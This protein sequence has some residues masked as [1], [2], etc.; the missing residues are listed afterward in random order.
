MSKLFSALITVNIIFGQSTTQVLPR[1]SGHEHPSLTEKVELLLRMKLFYPPLGFGVQC[2]A[3]QFSHLT[4][5]STN[6]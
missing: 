5:P 4:V 6:I 3:E 2:A 1:D